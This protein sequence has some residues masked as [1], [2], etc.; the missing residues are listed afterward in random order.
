M[1]KTWQYKQDRAEVKYIK[2]SEEVATER[3]WKIRKRVSQE[4]TVE[5]GDLL[6]ADLDLGPPLAR[7]TPPLPKQG[8]VLVQGDHA[9]VHHGQHRIR[10]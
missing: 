7:G 2:E 5:L 10:F 6:E 1:P 8:G 9:H 3:S 4:L